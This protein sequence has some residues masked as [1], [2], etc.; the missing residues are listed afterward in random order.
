[1]TQSMPAPGHDYSLP[2]ETV[3]KCK[4]RI[5][6]DSG[7]G[8]KWSTGLR[9]NDLI[10]HQSFTLRCPHTDQGE[11]AFRFHAF[12]KTDTITQPLR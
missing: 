12:V 11:A 2:I 9:W 5:Q 10:S 7:F 6:P 3:G 8:Y 1:M 4:V